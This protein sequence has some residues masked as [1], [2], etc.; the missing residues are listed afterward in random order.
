VWNQ[1]L[2]GSVSPD[3]LAAVDRLTQEIKSGA[4]K[5]PAGF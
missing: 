1:K 5:P 4:V 2:Q 3:T